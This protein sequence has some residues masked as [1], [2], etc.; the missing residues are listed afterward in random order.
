MLDLGVGHLGDEPFDFNVLETANLDLRQHFEGDGKGEI[1]FCFER[2]LDFLRILGE[3]DLRLQGKP[4]LI[5]LD[6]LAIGLVDGLLDNFRHDRAAVETLEMRNRN[7]ARTEARNARLGLDFGELAFDS[8][9]KLGRGKHHLE[10]ALEALRVCLRDLHLNKP[11]PLLRRLQPRYPCRRTE[12]HANHAPTV[13]RSIAAASVSRRWRC[14]PAKVWCG[15]RDSNPHDFH[16]RNL[17]PAR[18][19]VPPRPPAASP[20]R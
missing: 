3:I 4:Q 8:L 15:R 10:F 6:N 18:L 19:P 5:V 7:L 11:F 16:H 1:G 20:P 13:A 12:P 14:A 9:G 2:L 17:N